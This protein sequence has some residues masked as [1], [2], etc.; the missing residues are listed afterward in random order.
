MKK[1]GI[2]RADHDKHELSKFKIK[3]GNT[4]LRS[5]KRRR[6]IHNIKNIFKNES[7]KKVLCIRAR[8]DSEVRDFKKH[9]ENCVGIDILKQTKHILKIDAH[10]IKENF[11][12]NEYDLVYASHCL[13]H[14]VDPEIVMEGIRYVSKFGCFVTL[15]AFDQLYKS[16]CSLFDISDYIF[17][18]E[19]TSKEDVFN[20]ISK[21]ENSYLFDDFLSF[22]KYSIEYFECMN[23]IKQSSK[24]YRERMKEFDIIFKWQH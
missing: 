2:T 7:I 15:P 14:M 20:N 19:I 21:E 12:E 9:F 1:L 22:G 8:H 24:D 3:K 13:E 5:K 10:E 4:H 17:N 11:S 18:H 16:H 6:D 23:I